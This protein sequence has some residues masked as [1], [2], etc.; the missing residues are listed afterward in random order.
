[1]ITT[2]L[3]DIIL[4]EPAIRGL[5][6]KIY[7]V[8][9]YASA[10]F[11][12]RHLEDLL[13]TN[14]SFELNLII[15]MPRSTYD[16]LAFVELHQ[17]YPNNFKA[18]YYQ[19]NPPVHSKVF[20]WFMD[21]RPILGYAGSANYS[22]Y[23]FFNHLQTNQMTEENPNEIYRFY[24]RLIN[25]SIPI[26]DVPTPSPPI[27]TEVMHDNASVSPGS[28]RWIVP[29]KIV[30]ISFLDKR[31]ILPRV[32]GLNWGQRMEKRT[33]KKTGAIS[34]V[35]RNPNQAYLSL[36]GDSRREGFLPNRAYTFTLITD[37]NHSFDCVVAQD[38]RK[39]IETTNNNS[40][41][42]EYMRHR[43]GVP[44]GRLITE[45]NLIQYGRT[46]YTI[47]KLNDETFIF[48]F[49]V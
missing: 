5:A 15:G 28:I 4:I 7:A 46:D 40:E 38:G 17:L 30:R 24:S 20:S 32:S 13:H 1:M 2:E 49:S 45:E 14:N 19:G 27:I 36:K 43:I 25:N 31:G 44:L 16:H 3:Y 41:L 37:D 18:Y 26:L 42:G 22:Q 33:N 8:S 23:G 21:D 12:K 35:K 39:A 10:T 34:W 11:A 29:N 47:E 48:D 9:G 6:N